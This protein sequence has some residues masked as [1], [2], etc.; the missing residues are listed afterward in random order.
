MDVLAQIPLDPAISTA[1]D[2]GDSLADDT[3]AA[4]AIG[5]LVFGE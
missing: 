1:C 5:K 3:P 4:A 2:G